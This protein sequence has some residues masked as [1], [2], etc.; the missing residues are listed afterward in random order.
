MFKVQAQLGDAVGSVPNHHNKA[1][2]T[3][4]RVVIT[5]LVEGL[6]FDLLKKKRGKCDISEVP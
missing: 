5:V 2:I 6:A 4:K 1:R 3:I